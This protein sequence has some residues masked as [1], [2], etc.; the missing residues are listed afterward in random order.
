MIDASCGA[1]HVESEIHAV[2][3]VYPGCGQQA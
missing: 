3:G 1:I 2:L